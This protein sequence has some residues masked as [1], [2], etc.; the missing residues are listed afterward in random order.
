M[1]VKGTVTLGEPSI[2]SDFD[3]SEFNITVHFPID[4]DYKTID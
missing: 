4:I 2:T 3:S 1:T